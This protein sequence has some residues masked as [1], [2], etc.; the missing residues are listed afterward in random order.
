ME[1]S[2][3]NPNNYKFCYKAVIFF[4]YVYYIRKISIY[5]DLNVQ[6]IWLNGLKTLKYPK[7]L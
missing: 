5:L 4:L 2:N 6:Y 3:F 1:K 7:C